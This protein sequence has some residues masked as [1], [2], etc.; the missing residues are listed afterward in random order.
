MA[1]R[2]DISQYSCVPGASDTCRGH[3]DHLSFLN[4]IIILYINLEMKQITTMVRK[5]MERV[6]FVLFHFVYIKLG[7]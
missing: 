5:E 6:K 1:M 3:F 2:K 4:D 7:Q